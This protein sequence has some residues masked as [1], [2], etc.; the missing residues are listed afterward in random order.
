M[1]FSELPRERLQR[2]KPSSRALCTLV[3]GVDVPR[4]KDRIVYHREVARG[5]KRVWLRRPR[6]ASRWNFVPDLKHRA[7]PCL[8]GFLRPLGRGTQSRLARDRSCSDSFGF[9]EAA[10]E[11]LVALRRSA[12]TPGGHSQ[13]PYMKRN[14]VC[15]LLALSV[16]LTAAL[17]VRAA[18]PSELLTPAR[19]SFIR[20]LARLGELHQCIRPVRLNTRRTRAALSWS[21]YASA[22]R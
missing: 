10:N 13:G 16:S 3:R 15:G 9:C 5:L 14:M 19:S 22:L 1:T 20:V 4:S 18:P 21:Q 7:L 8:M 12:Q 6:E 11:E 2:G 17:R